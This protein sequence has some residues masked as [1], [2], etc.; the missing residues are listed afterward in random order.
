MSLLPADV[1]LRVFVFVIA[2]TIVAI[3]FATIVFR[4]TI[5]V[6]VVF[7]IGLATMVFR[8]TI[9]VLV[10]AIRLATGLAVLR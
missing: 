10:F 9:L 3:V 2:S 4:T 5:L 6:L 7:A 1:A 8:T